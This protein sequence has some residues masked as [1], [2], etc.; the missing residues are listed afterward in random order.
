MPGCRWL[1]KCLDRHG[2][3]ER[4][5]RSDDPTVEPLVLKPQ[6]QESYQLHSA[7]VGAMEEN[8]AGGYVARLCRRLPSRKADSPETQTRKAGPNPRIRA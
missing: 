1:A 4:S 8:P 5:H 3:L 7:G 2:A 6:P